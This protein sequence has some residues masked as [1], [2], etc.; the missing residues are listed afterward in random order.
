MITT[1]T[2]T[3]NM[4]AISSM[5]SALNKKPFEQTYVGKKMLCSSLPLNNLDMESLTNTEIVYIMNSMKDHK[6]KLL[7]SQSH[8]LIK[9]IHNN[10]ITLNDI[11]FTP[12]LIASIFAHRNTANECI[13]DVELFMP[14][15]N[16]YTQ[17][18]KD[19]F[20]YNL[21]ECPCI[22]TA[23]HNN[24]SDSIIMTI[25]LLIKNGARRQIVGTTSLCKNTK[26]FK[27]YCKALYNS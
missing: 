4:Y 6:Y 27:E 19:D 25:N 20:L 26:L 17:T 18:Q 24:H 10:V 9:M 23:I 5:L 14:T 13:A 21:C 22:F 2:I 1:S 12:R 15:F 3:F 11:E 16:T 8:V 7:K